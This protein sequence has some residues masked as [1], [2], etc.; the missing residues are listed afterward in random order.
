M[1]SQLQIPFLLIDWQEI[2]RIQDHFKE[3][4]LQIKYHKRA[5]KGWKTRKKNN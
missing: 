5:V 4:N 3:Q 1:R 2:A